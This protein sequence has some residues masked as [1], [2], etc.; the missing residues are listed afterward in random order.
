MGPATT[1][2]VYES[3]AEPKVSRYNFGFISR[4]VHKKCVLR[5]PD[6]TNGKHSSNDKYELTEAGKMMHPSKQCVREEWSCTGASS[7]GRANPN[8]M[9]A[10]GVFGGCREG[11]GMEHDK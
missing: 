11:C 4:V 3:D 8:C 9:R 5:V 10:C 7:Y 1:S 6:E 2:F